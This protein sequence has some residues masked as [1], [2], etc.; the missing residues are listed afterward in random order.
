MQVKV[1][2]GIPLSG[3]YK[4]APLIATL[5]AMQVGDS[6]LYPVD[7]RTELPAVAKKANVKIATRKQSPTEVRVWRIA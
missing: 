5:A 4:R 2:S 1:E 3:G 6:F 7:K